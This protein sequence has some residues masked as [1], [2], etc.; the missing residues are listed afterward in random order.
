MHL[1]IGA[2]AVLP[3][4]FARLEH[5]GKIKSVLL[6]VTLQHPPL[7]YLV[8][9]SK[10]M[11]VYG[12]RAHISREWT[13]KYMAS[14]GLSIPPEIRIDNTIPALV[15]FSTETITALSSA[16]AVSWV[17]E[18]DFEDVAAL[19]NHLENVTADPLAF[20]GFA[21]GGLL[22]V[23]MEAENEGEMPALIRRQAI[24]HR[25][26]LAWAFVFHFPRV[27]AG[28]PDNLEADRLAMM[29]T[30]VAHLSPE[31]GTIVTDQLWPALENDDI[32]TFGRP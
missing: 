28:T 15:G 24:K 25:D 19:A 8:A 17:N 22:L 27:P 4:A 21:Q 23:E 12:P 7:H 10:T 26:H 11:N 20:W 13:Q 18:T 16:Q 1:E 2:P 3:L 14:S 32:E 31:S 30:A 5:E 9:K 6:G 29:K